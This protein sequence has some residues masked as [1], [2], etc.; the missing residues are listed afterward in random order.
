MVGFGRERAGGG[1]TMSNETKEGLFDDCK[2][3]RP[4]NAMMKCEPSDILIRE[5]EALARVRKKIQKL[6]YKIKNIWDS[7]EVY[8]SNIYDLIDD[9]F[10]VPSAKGG[11]KK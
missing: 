1:E 8:E 11:G 4:L 9:V 7:N 5:D 6:K 2:R 10:S 3:M